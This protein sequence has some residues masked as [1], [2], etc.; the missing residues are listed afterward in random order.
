M[1]FAVIAIGLLGVVS[2]ATEAGTWYLSR[3]AADN[4]ADAAAVS[5]ALAVSAGADYQSAGTHT[6]TRDGYTAGSGVTITVNNPP[7]T[8]SYTTNNAAAEVLINVT[9][10]PLLSSLFSSLTPV[11]AS[12]GVALVA[13]VG[14]A[15]VLSLLGDLQITQK[16]GSLGSSGALGCVYASNA[17]DSTAVDIPSAS[18]TAYTVTS[19]GSCTGCN[20]PGNTLLR[21]AASYQPPTLNSF[22]AVD[23]LSLP[24]SFQSVCIPSTLPAAYTLVPATPTGVFPTAAAGSPCT[25]GGST[26]T[27]HTY[28]WTTGQPY[29]AYEGNLSIP[30]GTTLTLVP[31]TY[32]FVNA[33]LTLNGGTIRCMIST[34]VGSTACH[35]GSQGVTII[36]LGNPSS[37]SVGNLTIGSA[38]A[39][40]LSALASQSST[41]TNSSGLGSAYA[42]LD[43]LL[44]YRRGQGTGENVGAPGVN[45]K[46]KATSP[47]TVLN[48][49]MYFPN[50]YV[51]YGA[52]GCASESSSCTP[53]CSI[54]VAGYLSL[55]NTASQFS[56]LNC[57]SVYNTSPPQIQAVR[58]GE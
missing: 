27:T 19:V 24:T 43:G 38:A 41:F 36:M 48:G 3:S 7:A 30:A 49:G 40:S 55:A 53:G 16:Q 54:L 2:L 8:G 35:P 17:G 46:G 11:I 52:N 33:S 14:N 5:A 58:M 29:Y 9:A 51:S 20:N 4:A 45:I 23:S 15:C 10:T 37:S 47:Y 31:G 6:A 25:T 22:T 56:D 44:F 50:S 26:S 18:I 12:R 39:V 28:S 57:K 1:F 21:P 42:A 34:S 13:P 32:F